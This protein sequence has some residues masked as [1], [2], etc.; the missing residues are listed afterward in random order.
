MRHFNP[1]Y[2]ALAAALSLSVL[3]FG[4]GCAFEDGNPWG[5]ADFELTASF[6]PEVDSGGRVVQANGYA[7]ELDEVT[8]FFDSISAT[9]SGEGGDAGFDPAEPPEGYTLCHN[10][11]CHADDGRLVDY[12]DVALELSGG[13]GGFRVTQAVDGPVTLADELTAATLG[14]CSDDCYLEYGELAA[15]ELAMSGIRLRGRV[16]D[17]REGDAAR[18]P[19]EGVALSADL[20]VDVTYRASISGSVDKDS[21]IGVA[22][23]ADLTLDDAIFTGIDWATY[24]RESGDAFDFSDADALSEALSVTIYDDGRFTADVH[25]FDP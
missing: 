8:V 21:P 20:S 13:G 15:V 14:A 6:S 25:R 5:E 10:G 24:L 18:L 11:H 9:M 3:T 23:D 7:L 12:E 22:I 4:A 2:A 19:D 16:F 1:R 17:T